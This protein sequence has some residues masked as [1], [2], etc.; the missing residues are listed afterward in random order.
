MSN[1][2]PS[3]SNVVSPDRVSRHSV[4]FESTNDTR[5]SSRYVAAP[6]KTV[7][8]VSFSESV[9]TD[10]ADKRSRRSGGTGTSS[11]SASLESSGQHIVVRLIES[12]DDE[13]LGE[14]FLWETG[15]PIFEVRLGMLKQATIYRV[16]FIVRDNLPPGT[17]ELL[18]FVDESPGHVSVPVNVGAKIESFEAEPADIEADLSSS[19]TDITSSHTTTSGGSSSHTNTT[20]HRIILKLAT[21]R[22]PRV[23]ELFSMRLVENPQQVV[24]LI[25]HGRS[26]GRGQGTPF[27]R[28]GIRRLGENSDCEDSDEQTEWPGFIQVDDQD[29]EEGDPTLAPQGTS[30]VNQGDNADYN[31]ED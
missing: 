24:Y 7:R 29:E 28:L 6:R 11:Y 16:E 23:N 5:E 27:L 9:I 18:R 4:H 17:L 13:A 1:N 21:T 20:G 12:K 14:S 26:L 31:K 10:I 22:Q 30:N 25:F 8:R 19:H 3:D 15:R 2:K